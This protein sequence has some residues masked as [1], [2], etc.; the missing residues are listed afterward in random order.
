ML[1]AAFGVFWILIIYIFTALC[2]TAKGLVFEKLFI[3]VIPF[4]GIYGEFE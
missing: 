1:K 4:K 2:Y 3:L